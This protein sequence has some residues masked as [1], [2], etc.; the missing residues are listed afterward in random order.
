MKG[1]IVTCPDCGKSF[2]LVHAERGMHIHINKK[3]KH[4]LLPVSYREA[5]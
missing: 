1:R 2:L 5:V 4:L 3:K